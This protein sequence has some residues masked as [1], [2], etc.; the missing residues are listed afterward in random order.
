MFFFLLSNCA[1]TNI[2]IVSWYYT[3]ALFAP[4]HRALYFAIMAMVMMV[5]L[6]PYYVFVDWTSLGFHRLQPQYCSIYDGYFWKHERYWKIGMSISNFLLAMLNGTPFK[7]LVW[8]ALGVRV[9]KK[10]FDDGGSI[11]EK[12]LVTIGDYCTLNDHCVLQAHSLEDGVFKSG[13]I[14]IGDGCTIGAN[15]YVHYGV[16]MDNNV[17][18]EPDSFLMKGERPEAQTSWHGNPAKQMLI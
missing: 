12:T 17:N 13:H 4:E 9:G 10:L 3:Y 18:L 6:I 14:F 5:I 2:V 1:A 8:R 16:Y 11:P 7:N 15:C